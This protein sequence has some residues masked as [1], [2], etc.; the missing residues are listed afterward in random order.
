MYQILKKNKEKAIY[1]I[2]SACI[3]VFFLL[4]T[5]AFKNDE[6]IDKKGKNV[7][8]NQKDLILIKEFLLKKIKSPF[9]SIDYKIKGGDSIQKILK[10][11]KVQNNEIQTIISQYKKYGNPNQLLTDNKIEIIVKENSSEK[12]NLIVKFSVPI[13]KSTTIEITT[14][15]NARRGSSG[16][17]AAGVG[18]GGII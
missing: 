2:T 1:F 7:S 11:F 18:A 15:I 6:E 12:D 16:G 10:K 17:G 14:R 9:T 13:T 8:F 3:V 4:V 5:V